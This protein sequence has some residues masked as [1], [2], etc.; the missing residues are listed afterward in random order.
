MKTK[1]FQCPET[2]LQCFIIALCA[3]FCSPISRAA[4]FMPI[5]T[6]YAAA[7]YNAGLQN[8][9][10]AQGE[11]GDIFIGNNTGLLRFDGYRWERYTIP[12]RQIVRSIL[13]D[14][15]RIYVGTYREFGFFEPDECG[16][17]VFTSLHSMVKRRKPETRDY[18]IWNIV[19][20]NGKIYFQS[21]SSW[22]VY[23]GKTVR[24]HY[25]SDFL[26]LY[27]HRIDNRIFVQM[28]NGDF[29]QLINEQMHFAFSREEVG[30]DHVVAIIPKTRGHM[31]LCTEWNGLYDFDGQHVTRRKTEIDNELRSQQVN[32]ATML[33][34]DSTIIIGTIRNGIY[35]INKQGRCLWHCNMSNRLYNNSVLSLFVDRDNNIWSC[36]DNGVSLIHTGSPYSLLRPDSYELSLGMVYGIDWIDSKMYI[37]TNQ[38]AYTFDEISGSI[39]PINGAQGQNWHIEHFPTGQIFIGNTRPLTLNGNSAAPI[40]ATTNSSSTCLHE[41][42][43]HGQQV[44]L[45]S[46]YIG[47]RVYRK[48]QGRWKLACE[49]N[50]LNIPLRHF[51][52]DHSG[53]I[54]AAHMSRGLYK[55]ELD[56][57]LSRIANVTPLS[58]IPGGFEGGIMFVM[59]IQGRVMFAHQTHLYTY[60]DVNNRIIPVDFLSS[61]L[62]RN[63]NAATAIDTHNYWISSDHDY[64]LINISHNSATITQTV[65]ARF[66]GTECN[67]TNNKILVHRN[68]AYFLLNNAIGRYSR[69]DMPLPTS[70]SHLTFH[71]ITSTDRDNNPIA[72]PLVS[73]KS[74]TA[75]TLGDITFNLSLP[76][77]DN[78][79]VYF[80]YHLEGGGIDLSSQSQNPQISY[81]SLAYGQYHFTADALNANHEPIGTVEYHFS[82]PRPFYLSFVAICIY[83][84]LLV[85]V[86][87]FFTRWRTARTMEDRRR[88]YEAEKVKQDL[89]MM[90]QQRII[91]RQQQQLLQ[92]ELSNKGKEIASLALD[93]FTKDRAIESLRQLV[94]KKHPGGK[95]PQA[96]VDSLLKQINTS[97]LQNKEFWD[98]Y[99][100]NFDLI[101]ENFFRNLRQRYPALTPSD[102]KFC[103]FLRLNLSTKDIANITN[104]TIRGVEAARYRLRRKL[105]LPEGTSLVDF[106]IDFK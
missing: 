77:F 9:S 87:Y 33:R 10:C 68:D 90:E 84:V 67:E 21:F 79:I 64:T 32:R 95:L 50:T 71:R 35:A 57:S 69:R 93:V 53:S 45:E 103:A 23:D 5:V 96:E 92:S 37:A 102:L 18:D 86:T 105:Q 60:D 34:G 41:C 58:Q 14:G 61:T 97:N 28:M 15:N 22:F 56:K 66:F 11:N 26:P 49:I 13:A 3:C 89:K 80:R 7:D 70:V 36:L 40:P 91:D 17:M 100:A 19:K 8:W 2:A 29:Y 88:E 1:K 65:A 52:V 12:N 104:L 55:I 42:T 63:V 27:F 101:H 75:E 74:A 51:E 85:A 6:S 78:S 31:I 43:I 47:F 24:E 94:G 38:G 99:Q 106:F 54:W 83:V 4:S 76:H 16:N 59:K 82:V 73:D 98:L 20:L 30:D 25:D 46:S 44:L 62:K 39:A 81:T 48:D 72:L